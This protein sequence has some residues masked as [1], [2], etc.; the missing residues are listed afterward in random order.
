MTLTWPKNPKLSD[1]I[2]TINAQDVRIATLEAILLEH[3]AGAVTRQAEV[4]ALKLEANRLQVESTK[5][6][7]A[8]LYGR[9]Q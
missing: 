1:L 8:Q 6:R 2:E 3:E 7:W 9:K 4:D 5:L